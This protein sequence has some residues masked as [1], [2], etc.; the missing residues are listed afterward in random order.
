MHH[1]YF[2]LNFTTLKN[3]IATVRIGY[4]QKVWTDEIGAEWIK[5]FDKQT[6]H[7]VKKGEYQLLIVDGH[8]SILLDFLLP[9]AQPPGQVVDTVYNALQALRQIRFQITRTRPWTSHGRTFH[10]GSILAIDPSYTETSGS[11]RFATRL[12]LPSAYFRHR[13]RPAL[14]CRFY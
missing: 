10:R 5:I 7:K 14:C 13:I 12:S 11:P 3:L 1:A 8:N 2:Y 6:K 9:R 4:S